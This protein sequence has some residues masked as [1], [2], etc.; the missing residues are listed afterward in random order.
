[1]PY[2]RLCDFA[3]KNLINNPISVSLLPG[4]TVDVTAYVVNEN[5]SLRELHCA[6]GGA[7]GGTN[8]DNLFFDLLD[9]IFGKTVLQIFQKNSPSDYQEILKSFEVKKRSFGMETNSTKSEKANLRL[10]FQT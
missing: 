3:G 5:R 4:G 7:V 6:T 10:H 8:V 2:F 9:K 1:M